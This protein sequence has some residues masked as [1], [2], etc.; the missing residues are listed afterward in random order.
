M[1]DRIEKAITRVF[2]QLN[3][4]SVRQSDFVPVGELFNEMEKVAFMTATRYTRRKMQ[5][6]WSDAID[7]Q[8]PILHG[9]MIEIVGE[10][11][12]ID[13]ASLRVKTNIYVE[14]MLSTTREFFVCAYF[15]YV[16]ADERSDRPPQP[17]HETIP[18]EPRFVGGEKELRALLNERLFPKKIARASLYKHLETL[19]IRKGLYSKTDVDVL[20]E[21]IK[22]IKVTR[23]K[24]HE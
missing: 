4:H 20:I 13:I 5:A 7:F 3:T 2:Q 1:N 6:T 17:I 8:K 23:T 15:T 21:Y 19:K 24:N 14:Q 18:A 12:E 11:I 16:V 22:T 10:V 9:A